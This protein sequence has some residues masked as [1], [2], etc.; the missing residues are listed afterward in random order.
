M[1]DGNRESLIASPSVRLALPFVQPAISAFTNLGPPISAPWVQRDTSVFEVPGRTA[2]VWGFRF[3]F[4]VVY[5]PTSVV[6]VKGR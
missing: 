2:T 3:T 6:M 4:T 1:R 5:D